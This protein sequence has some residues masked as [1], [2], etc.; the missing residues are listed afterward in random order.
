MVLVEHSLARAVH[1][2]T[3]VRLVLNKGRSTKA[4]NYTMVGAVVC[5]QA[6]DK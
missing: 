3:N 1:T 2:I 5:A 6:S 4:I